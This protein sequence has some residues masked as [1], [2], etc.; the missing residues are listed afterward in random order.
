MD[1]LPD[2]ILALFVAEQRRRAELP[3]H[4]KVLDPGAAS[5]AARSSTR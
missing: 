5:R 3:P 4:L 2:E 1:A